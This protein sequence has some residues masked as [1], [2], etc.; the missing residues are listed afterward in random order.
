MASDYNANLIAELYATDDAEQATRISDEMVT[1]GD[2]IFPRQIYEAYKKFKDTTVSHYF[3]SDLTSFKTA[4]ASEFLKEIARDSIKNNDISIMVGYLADIAFFAPDIISKVR[5]AF[6]ND[7]SSGDMLDF[8]VDKYFLYLEKSG[9]NIE[10]LEVLLRK[11]LEDDH[12]N[13]PTRK[14]ALKK[15]LKLKPT[16]YV[17]FYLENYDILKGRK[18]EV[19]LVEEISTW[20]GGKVSL[21]HK[22]I[23]DSGSERAKEILM[24]EQSRIT[25]EKEA[26]EI[27]EQKE[28]RSEFETADVIS[29]IAMLRSKVNKLSTADEKFGFAFFQA[30][31][32]IYQQGKPARDKATL[33]G[34]CMA[35]RPLLGGFTEKVTEFAVS[36]ERAL[37][38]MP[39]LKDFN[40]SI[41]KFHLLLLEKGIKVD[42]GLFGLR[43]ISRMITKFAAHTDEENSP[44]LLE[45]LRKE[46][47]YYVYKED[48]WSR[49]H[50]EILLKYKGVLDKLIE[51]LARD[52]AA[53]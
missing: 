32:E 24:K 1:I 6:E 27:N 9:E 45:I 16:E 31:E 43:N 39:D 34:Y 42:S 7:I 23:L 11:C 19:I 35:L 37:E 2:P 30:S 17:N 26:R 44:E 47:L 40:G 18:L 4:D 14:A 3:I 49:F 10:R 53:G 28:V 25:K 21:L 20:H 15:L 41:N 29:D 51:S 50:R 46:G 48:N 52:A 33:I 36:R 13:I 22:K 5:E 38:L 8:E 12:Q